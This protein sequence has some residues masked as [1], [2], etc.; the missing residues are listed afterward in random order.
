MMLQDVRQ[1]L[2]SNEENCVV[3]LLKPIEPQHKAK[4][5]IVQ[6][7]FIVIARENKESSLSTGCVIQ[8]NSTLILIDRVLSKCVFPY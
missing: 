6:K 3:K 8:E 1:V 4:N 2:P 7:K 5:G